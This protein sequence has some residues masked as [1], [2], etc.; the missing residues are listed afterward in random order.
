M[1][2]PADDKVALAFAAETRAMSCS[3]GHGWEVGGLADGHLLTETLSLT[4]AHVSTSGKPAAGVQQFPPYVRVQRS[5]SLG[6]DWS[7][8]TTVER[9]SPKEGGFA[10]ALPILAGEH[11]S[12]AGMKVLDGKVTAAI[13]DGQDEA[14]WKSTLDK[15]DT[16]TLTAPALS[17]H[18][19]T[20]QVL[21]SPTWHCRFQLACRASA[22]P[23]TKTPTIIAISNF[24]Q[25]G[26]AETLTLKMRTRPAAVRKARCVP[27]TP[28][29]STA[30]RGSTP[31]HMR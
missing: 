19:E 16:L 27:S 31:R 8:T 2:L 13:G 12:T 26:L 4:R 24:I 17:D 25:L 10:V 3:R 29:R 6:L 15:A 21:I 1:L 30:K 23:R 9:L 11:I 5:L 20:W 14:S 7:A 18:A 28:W 22:S